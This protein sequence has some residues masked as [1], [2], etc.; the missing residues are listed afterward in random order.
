MICGRVHTC[1]GLQAASGQV[2][3]TIRFD[4]AG[5]FAYAA[6]EV[7]IGKPMGLES[8]IFS[9]GV[10]L[11]E[12]QPLQLLVVARWQLLQHEAAYCQSPSLCLQSLLGGTWHRS[13]SR[14]TMTF[15]LQLV[16]GIMPVS[17]GNLPEPVVPDECPLDVLELIHACTAAEPEA[18]PTAKQVLLTAMRL[19]D[20]LG[21]LS[22][23]AEEMRA[24]TVL[25]HFLA[26]LPSAFDCSSFNS[27][28]TIG[29]L[30]EE[31][32]I[33]RA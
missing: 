16:S 31:W 10:V 17:R 21:T 32:Y 11:H 8:D 26:D 6:P 7:I 15:A 3:E 1:G 25:L 20:L 9:M 18:R 5:T 22:N 29:S 30:V 28:G 4:S 13:E 27:I 2:A 12:V 33:Q 23:I 14:T 24:W 19:F